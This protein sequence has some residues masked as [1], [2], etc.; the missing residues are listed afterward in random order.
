MLVVARTPASVNRLWDLLP[1]ILSDHRIEVTFAVD[2][3]SAFSHPLPEALAGRGALIKDWA[4]AVAADYDLALAASDN[5]ELHRLRAPLIRVPHG[6][7]FHRNAPAQQGVI[8]GLR[9]ESLVHEGTI[10]PDTLVVAHEDQAA[11]VRAVAPELA[12]R[13]LVAGDPCMDRIH[14]ST[15]RRRKYREALAATDRQLILLCSTWGRFSLYGSD[16][17]LPAWITAALPADRYRVALVLHP[18]VW[19]RHGP[20]Q[21]EAWLRHAADAGMIVV[22]HEEGWRAAIVA[23]DLVISDHGSLTSYSVGLRRPVVL[24]ADGGPEVVAES[25]MRRLIDRLPRLDTEKPLL[26]QLDAAMRRGDIAGDIAG[27]IF[28]HPGRSAA[29]LRQRMYEV[30]GLSEPPWN[31]VARPLPSPLVKITEPEAFVVQAVSDAKRLVLERFPVVWRAEDQPDG[32]LAVRA[33]AADP[34]LSERA[35]VVWSDELEDP[36]DLLKRWPGARIAICRSTPNSSVALLRDG[37]EVETAGDVPCS[38][39]GSALYWWDVH[40]R[41]ADE[42][43]DIDAGANSGTLTLSAVRPAPRPSAG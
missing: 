5:G 9:P 11:T 38:V 35:A 31:A 32:H 8:S 29:L 30:L 34:E 27:T 37:T 39:A 20:L 22:P 18:N 10:V 24:A 6:V 16:P 28:A 15:P 23:A 40:N 2:K 7:G 12:S 19:T 1:L 41:R 13:V 3:G 17:D 42:R 4:E 33:D 25:P 14:A 43:L 21:I 36:R 26:P